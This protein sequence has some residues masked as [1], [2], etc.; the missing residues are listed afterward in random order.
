ML[1]TT[2][3]MTVRDNGDVLLTMT[4]QRALTVRNNVA[5]D[6]GAIRKDPVDLATKLA[7]QIAGRVDK[8]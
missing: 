3:T 1:S 4:A 5:I 6:V 8:Q 2:L 7:G